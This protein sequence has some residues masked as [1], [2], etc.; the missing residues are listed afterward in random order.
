MTISMDKKYYTRTGLPVRVVCVDYKNNVNPSLTVLCLITQP[1]GEE[2]LA[3]R[4]EDGAED[5]SELG[6]GVDI[7]EVPPWHDI[8]IDEP[9]VATNSKGDEYKGHFAGL[10]DKR[11]TIWDGGGTSWITTSSVLMSS[12][13]RPT[14]E[15][16]DQKRI[17]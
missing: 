8:M 1:T 15:E 5:S 4:N 17:M 3:L 11:P 10:I 13:R 9:V 6:L 7:I 2:L 12:C 14:P 16:L